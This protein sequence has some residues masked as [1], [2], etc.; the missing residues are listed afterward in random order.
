MAYDDTEAQKEIIGG[1][2]DEIRLDCG[3]EISETLVVRCWIGR[4]FRRIAAE[5]NHWAIIDRQTVLPCPQNTRFCSFST[6]LR[7]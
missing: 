2:T 4:T 5:S 3:Q 6:S 7:W 1:F